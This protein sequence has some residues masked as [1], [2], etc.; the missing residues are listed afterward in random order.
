[1]FKYFLKIMTLISF[2]F[3]V[4]PNNTIAQCPMCKIGAESNLK[5]GGA[6]GKGLNAGILFMLSMPY[7]IVGGIGYMWWRN[8]K[9][10]ADDVEF[11]D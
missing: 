7:L 11:T 3:L 6:A 10:N 8:R 2:L 5:N 1:M 9:K 4:S